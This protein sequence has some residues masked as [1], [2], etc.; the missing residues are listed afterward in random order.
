[1]ILPA[2][3]KAYLNWILFDEQFR[4]VPEGSGFIRV[5]Y[6][7]DGRL[8][9]LAQSGLPIVKNGY[10]FVYLSNES[11]KPVFFDNLV[12]QHYPGPLVEEMQ[13]Y[14]FGLIMSGI[15]SKTL[16]FGN[17]SNKLK[18]TGKEE[19][20]Q[21]FSDG[22]GLEWTDF[23]ARMYDNQIMRWM[24]ID[25]LADKMR[26]HSPYNYAFDNPIRFIDPDGMAPTWIVGEDGK[27]VKTTVKNGQITVGANAT[28]DT[29]KLVGLINASG[30]TT[31]VNQF[32]KIANSVTKTHVIVD[33]KN[34][35]ADG[36]SL[37]GYH[38]PHDANGNTLAYK[39]DPNKQGSGKF[40]GEIAFIK[41]NNGKLAF[42]EATITVFEKSFTPYQVAAIDDKYGNGSGSLTKGQAMVSTFSHEIDHDVNP[43]NINAMKDRQDGKTNNANVE[44]PAYKITKKVI[45]E[46]QKQNN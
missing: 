45:S 19:Q 42:K 6:Y 17:P 18:F 40:D 35:G 39:V 37:L 43:I 25:P 41:D 32:Q 1:M 33:T 30:S 8:Q 11:K 14:P 5:G 4:Y 34:T 28:A 26:R 2:P 13:Y 22:S 24:T 23:G 9:T 12:V 3:P 21:E 27:K 36:F 29:K 44:T 31:A 46:I 38:Q 16:S 7:D 15:S 20:R 10:L